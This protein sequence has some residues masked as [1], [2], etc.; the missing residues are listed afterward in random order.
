MRIAIVCSCAVVKKD[1]KKKLMVD[2]DVS[3]KKIV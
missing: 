2:C 1:D 3:G